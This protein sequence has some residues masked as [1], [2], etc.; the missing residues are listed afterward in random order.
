[1]FKRK[2]KTKQE[3]LLQLTKELYQ[4]SQKEAELAKRLEAVTNT[5]IGGQDGTI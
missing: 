3:Q 5:I 1:M 4:L 2:A